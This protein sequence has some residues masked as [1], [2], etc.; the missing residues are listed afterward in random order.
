MPFPDEGF[1]ERVEVE[2][3]RERWADEAAAYVELLRDLAP[4]AVAI[5]HI[6]STSVP[7]LP[8]K[9]C[10][11]LMVQVTELD[12]GITSALTGRG[13]RLRPEAWNREEVTDGV[14]HR[15][16]V[17]AGPVG[18]RRVNVHVRGAG[19]RNVRYALLFRDFLRANRAA[20][21]TWGAFKTR[22]AETATDVFDY[23][24][25]KAAVQ[26]L[27]MECAE[28]WAEVT[29]WDGPTASPYD[30]PPVLGVDGCKAGWVGALLTVEGIEV[31][32]ARNIAD[33]VASA[34]GRR[35]GLQVV[36]VDMPIGL[37]DDRP[38]RTDTAARLALPVGRKSSVFSTP[39][40][41]ATEPETYPEA[42]A[43]NREVLGRGISQQAFRLIPK[44]LEADAYVRG[45]PP[46]PVLEAHPEVSFAAIAPDCV[47]PSKK[48]VEGARTR[49]AALRSVGLEPPAY[50]RG[51][52]YAADDLLDACV[53]AWTAARYA[54]G[55]AYSLPDPPEVFS[56][57]I[58]A[59]IWV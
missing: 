35:P 53:V 36:A 37:P 6:G 45:G 47:V 25:I 38:R 43:A 27:L 7:G 34:R 40:R 13:F 1:V 55:T 44:I 42:S 16:L 48:S 56:D 21:E 28:H 39:S 9:D 58:P 50:V 26:P 18:E 17:F 30:G 41:A 49:R 5:D 59:A 52:G 57:G 20:R 10:L 32:V 14:G 3:Y 11:D 8:A 22:L 29:G 31:Q 46:V 54:A 12:D 19:G 2:P 15:K 51:Q 4:S 24:Q 33:L 23:G